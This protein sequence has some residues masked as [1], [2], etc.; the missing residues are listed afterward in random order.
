MLSSNITFHKSL[1][2]LLI[3]NN[4]YFYLNLFLCKIKNEPNF[5]SD[6]GHPRRVEIETCTHT[7]ETSGRARFASAGQNLHTNIHPSCLVP[8]GFAG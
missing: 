7:R 3:Q 5:W 8:V 1:A 6:A 4:N 2:K